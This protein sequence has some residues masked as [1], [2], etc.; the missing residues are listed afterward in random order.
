[1]EGDDQ[2]LYHLGELTAEVRLIND[3]FV[4]FRDSVRT[5][6]EKLDAKVSK[7]DE[8]LRTNETK[9]TELT[10]KVAMIAVAAGGLG[11]ALMSM[12]LK[13]L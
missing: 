13:R 9:I 7:F 1:M 10:V 5:G 11:S 12:V 6:F 4:E 3:Q 8:R 2:L